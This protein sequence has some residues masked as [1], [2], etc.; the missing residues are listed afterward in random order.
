MVED[1]YGLE[2]TSLSTKLVAELINGT[3]EIVTLPVIQSVLDNH[4]VI[5]G[6]DDSTPI[7]EDLSDEAAQ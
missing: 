5:M 4:Y 7:G 3:S 6:F 1:M 2:A